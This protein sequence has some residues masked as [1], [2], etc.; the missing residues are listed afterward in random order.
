MKTPTLQRHATGQYFTHWGGKRRYL[1][2]DYQRAR[3]RFLE[4]M[5]EWRQWQD[6]KA[7]NK[8]LAPSKVPLIIE[9]AEQFM[10]AKR[11]EVGLD[12]QEYYQKHL[13]RFLGLYGRY[14]ADWVRPK[15]LN[16]LKLDMLSERYAPKTINHDLTAIRVMFNW[17]SGLELIPPISFKGVKNLPLGPPPDKSRPIEEIRH[18]IRSANEHVRPWMAVNYLT[19]CRPSE[20]IKCV[21]RQGKWVEPGIFRLD[22]GKMDRKASF[23]RHVVFSEIALAWLDC[24]ESRYSRLDSYSQAVRDDC[25]FG[26]SIFRHSAAS[27]LVRD[28][29]AAPDVELLLGHAPRRLSVTYYRPAWPALRELAARLNL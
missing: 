18:A 23:P 26:P 27:H 2:K 20:V 4:S 15:H 21:D 10:D 29:V 19:A 12:A 7:A 24:C 1:G 22:R 5:D 14:R 8:P 6:D 13:R 16:A 3:A 28:G 25:G 9:V 17:A 11:V